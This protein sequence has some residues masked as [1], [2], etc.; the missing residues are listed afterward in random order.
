MYSTIYKSLCSYIYVSFSYILVS[1]FIYRSLFLYIGLLSCIMVSFVYI[2]E[3]LVYI[4]LD[5]LYIY[6][7][8]DTI[9]QDT[10][11]ISAVIFFFLVYIHLDACF[12]DVFRSMHPMISSDACSLDVCIRLF[13]YIGLFP[14]IL[15]SFH[16]S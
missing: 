9:I 8:R 7:K 4:H 1:F 11:P 13:S 14:C 16:A 2:Q 5:A 3:K 6:K 10:R 12:C 15:V